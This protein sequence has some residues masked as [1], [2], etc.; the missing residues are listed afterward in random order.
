MAHIHTRTRVCTLWAVPRCVGFISHTR[1]LRFSCEQRR[2][3]TVWCMSQSAAHQERKE[4]TFYCLV[5]ACEG[6]V[7]HLLHS[8]CGDL[9]KKWE[10]DGNRRPALST[11]PLR[12]E[13]LW[14]TGKRL[15]P[16]PLLPVWPRDLPQS[17]TRS[18]QREDCNWWIPRFSLLWADVEARDIYSHVGTSVW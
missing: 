5:W 6:V 7:S 11:C 13:E 16:P 18:E 10:E 9:D 12:L 17:Q 15:N 8:S 3:D 1:R 14:K 2:E 4:V